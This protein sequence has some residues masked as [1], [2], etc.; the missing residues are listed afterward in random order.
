M[1]LIKWALCSYEEI[2]TQSF[3]N[4]NT[5]WDMLTLPLLIKQADLREKN[6]VPRTLIEAGKVAGSATYKQS[7][8]VWHCVVL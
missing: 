3:N 4:Y 5:N 8:T 7:K 2:Q 1:N 6:K